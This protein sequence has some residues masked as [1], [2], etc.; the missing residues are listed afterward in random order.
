MTRRRLLIESSPVPE[1]DREPLPTPDPGHARAASGLAA[2]L[3][4]I[5]YPFNT[6]F[7]RIEKIIWIF[8]LYWARISI[9]GIPF[10]M[11]PG[12]FNYLL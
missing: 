2:L 12:I 5:F 6:C 3:F 10:E 8:C 11:P 4:K 7:S 1:D 9:K